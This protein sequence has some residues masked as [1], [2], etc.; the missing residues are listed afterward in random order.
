MIKDKQL[1]CESKIQPHLFS[2]LYYMQMM[3][4]STFIFP[5]LT[6]L[7]STLIFVSLHI[8]K[9]IKPIQSLTQ[10]TEMYLICRPQAIKSGLVLVGG[11]YLSVHYASSALQKCGNLWPSDPDRGFL[12]IERFSTIHLKVQTLSKHLSSLK[13]PHSAEFLAAQQ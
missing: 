8:F 6:T 12:Q 1:T 11:F 2:E 7:L 4:K 10:N 13:T 9:Q 5:N 3:L